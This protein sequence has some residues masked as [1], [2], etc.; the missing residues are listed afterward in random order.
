M[1]GWQIYV[2]RQRDGGG[3]PANESSPA[4]DHIA[5]WQ[6]GINGLDWLK[7]LTE[8]GNAVSL[9]GNGYPLRYTATAEYL[10]PLILTKRVIGDREPFDLQDDVRDVKPVL[11]ADKA[12]QYLPN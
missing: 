7:T 12:A 5:S 10:M 11:D 8:T 9:G 4:G 1:L 2:F 6:S 3:S